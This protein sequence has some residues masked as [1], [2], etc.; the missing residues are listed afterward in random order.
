MPR[1]QQRSP[2]PS[3]HLPEDVRP[4]SSV[5]AR[6]ARR[7]VARVAG[8]GATHALGEQAAAAHKTLTSPNARVQR[9]L[10]LALPPKISLQLVRLGSAVVARAARR[11]VA[12]V[13]GR[14][15]THAL[16]GTP[17]AAEEALG[18]PNACVEG[19]RLLALSPKWQ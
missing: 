13:A 15:A 6:A 7:R 9:T 8:R 10:R 11:R 19:T 18:G 4:G 17:A 14:G 3:P 12:R 1:Q 16:G 5:V 2:S